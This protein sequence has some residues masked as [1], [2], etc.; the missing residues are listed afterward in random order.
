MLILYYAVELC[1]AVRKA[2][3]LNVFNLNLLNSKFS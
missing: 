3:M 1:N 2:S